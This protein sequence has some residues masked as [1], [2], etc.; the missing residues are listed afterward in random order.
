MKKIKT[1]LIFLTVLL[2]MQSCSLAE[3]S[4]K[5]TRIENMEKINKE[6]A[7]V[8]AKQYLIEN[9]LNSDYY[10]NKVVKVEE[11]DWVEEKGLWIVYFKPK[12]NI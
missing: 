8:L 10:E 9:S 7:I 11:G 1:G 12:K 2:L 4:Q 3:Q 6:E 5:S